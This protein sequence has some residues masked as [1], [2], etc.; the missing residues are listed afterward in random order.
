MLNKHTFSLV[1]EHRLLAFAE[2]QE[3]QQ[4]AEK[5]GKEDEERARAIDGMRIHK[6]LG[7]IMRRVNG[8]GFRLPWEEGRA[9][10]EKLEAIEKKYE[11]LDASK[12]KELQDLKEE[13][14]KSFD[15]ILRANLQTR[16]RGNRHI[17]GA[18]LKDK[19]LEFTFELKDEVRAE[20]NDTY[21]I[22]R[23]EIRGATVEFNGP[24][25]LERFNESVGP[26]LIM[27]LGRIA[28]R[29]PLKG[30]HINAGRIRCEFTAE[31]D[32]QQKTFVVMPTDLF[33]MTAG[34]TPEQVK[35]WQQ[36]R[37]QNLLFRQ[38]VAILST[39]HQPLFAKKDMVR[40]ILRDLRNYPNESL[41]NINTTDFTA[42][43]KTAWAE[44]LAAQDQFKKNDKEIDRLQKT[45][46]NRSLQKKDDEGNATAICREIRSGTSFST[47]KK[48]RSS[49]SIMVTAGSIGKP[50]TSTI[51][52][53]RMSR[54]CE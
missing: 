14:L 16:L 24:V 22:T 53:T 27:C 12:A 10:R 29:F 1:A 19:T 5:G 18:K 30:L 49:I 52:Q 47:T 48:K 13:T 46:C 26:N 4:A 15:P 11:Q 9:L 50:I 32:D 20:L 3:K 31:E 33:E 35:T 8:I 37:L 28:K 42:D 7:D 45:I 40:T 41:T 6:D 43:Q 21:D 38:R 36:L 39:K 2:A 34:P 54:I 44:I 25:E 17:G 23:V 51:R